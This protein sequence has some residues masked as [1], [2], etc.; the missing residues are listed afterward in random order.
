MHRQGAPACP[1]SLQ[2]PKGIGCSLVASTNPPSAHIACLVVLHSQVF[3]TMSSKHRLTRSF[4]TIS[5]IL[6]LVSA[7][8]SLSLLCAERHICSPTGTCLWCHWFT[9]GGAMRSIRAMEE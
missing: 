3:A 2:T 4:R 1:R 9:V 7:F 6:Y 8:R 5:A